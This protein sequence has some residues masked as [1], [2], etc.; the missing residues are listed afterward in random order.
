[1]YRVLVVGRLIGWFRLM[2]GG[3][4]RLE[5]TGREWHGMGWSVRDDVGVP[6]RKN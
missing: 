5:G 6:H 1:M 4:C 3:G 2:V